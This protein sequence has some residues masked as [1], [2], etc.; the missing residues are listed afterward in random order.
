MNSGRIIGFIILG[1]FLLFFWFLMEK[2]AEVAPEVPIETVENEP[3]GYRFSHSSGYSMY[4]HGS[5]Y[6]SVGTPT[7]DGFESAVDLIVSENGTDTTF[8]SFDAFALS[9]A[10]TFCAADG[11]GE[12]MSCTDIMERNSFT[13]ESG[14]K[15]EE[16]YLTLVRTN[17]RDGTSVEG[18]FG[19]VFVF[20]ISNHAMGSE[21]AALFVYEP[22]YS[23]FENPNP[24]LVRDIAASVETFEP[25][26]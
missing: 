15:G 1:L 5:E 19:P 4:D 2:G 13:T 21:Y 20:D 25:R 22:L 18:R 24:D 11:P 12:S 26:R 8:E 7:E 23:F 14:L 3:Y 6:L 17:L 16:L 9:R 10:Q